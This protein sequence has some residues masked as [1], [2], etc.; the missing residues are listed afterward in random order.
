MEGLMAKL[1]KS[2]KKKAVKK[3]NKERPKVVEKPIPV[4]VEDLAPTVRVRYIGNQP[5]PVMIDGHLFNTEAE[6]PESVWEKLKS[7]PKFELCD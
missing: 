1:K 2:I 5:Q 6:V 7:H 4:E 3:I